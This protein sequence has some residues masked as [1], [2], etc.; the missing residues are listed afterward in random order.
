MKRERVAGMSWSRLNAALMETEDERQLAS[1]LEEALASS[2]LGLHR[3]LRIHGRL[4]CVRRAREIRE[5]R[6]RIALKR[7]EAA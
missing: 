6:A 2:S 5:I 4:N 1:W 7:E 3:M